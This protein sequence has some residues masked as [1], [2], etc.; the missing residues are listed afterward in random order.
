[1]GRLGRSGWPAAGWISSRVRLRSCRVRSARQPRRTSSYLEM[2]S[3]TSQMGSAGNNFA[4][5][6]AVARAH[7]TAPACR[8]ACA[9]GHGRRAR[10]LATSTPVLARPRGRAPTSES[11]VREYTPHF[12]CSSRTTRTRTKI[13]K[14]QNDHQSGMIRSQSA[15]PRRTQSPRFQIR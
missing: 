15:A 6:A 2:I 10:H 1:M 13:K 14:R 8:L 7:D 3:W 5:R 4:V 12:R 9:I 11:C